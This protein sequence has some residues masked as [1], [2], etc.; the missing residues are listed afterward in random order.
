MVLSCLMNKGELKQKVEAVLNKYPI[1]SKY[2]KEI[3]ENQ[4][5]NTKALWGY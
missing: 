5:S 2:Y 1:I 3:I 4:F